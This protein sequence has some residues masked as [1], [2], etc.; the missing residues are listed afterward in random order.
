[1]TLR[2]AIRNGPPSWTSDMAYGYHYTN[3]EGEEKTILHYQIPFD[4]EREAIFFARYG[5]TEA[6]RGQFYQRYLVAIERQIRISEC[7]QEA[8]I[9][10]ILTFSKVEQ[11]RDNDG[12]THILLETE[13]VWPVTERLF[14]PSVSVVTALEVFIRLSYILRDISKARVVHRGLD[15]REVYL[16]KENKIL[17]GGFYYADGPGI[18]STAAYLPQ[19]PVNLPKMFLSNVSGGQGQDIQTLA[20]IIWNVF[21]GVPYDARL[22]KNHLVYPEY[23]TDYLV[24]ALLLGLKGKAEDCN[25]F[26]RRLMDARKYYVQNEHMN[27]MLP[28]Q[29]PLLKTFTVNYVS[30]PAAPDQE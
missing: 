13:S 7:L 17:L 2:E 25:V 23:A 18:S 16:S 27:I 19:R 22:S 21:C 15:L 6:D 30:V 26:R 12:T 5:L 4:P 8:E 28:F 9:P 29:R 10:S 20:I 24:N 14:N 11:V 3:D 1:M